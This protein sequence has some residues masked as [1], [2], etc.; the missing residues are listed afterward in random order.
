M[1]L[2]ETLKRM[3]EAAASA[4]KVHW[5]DLRSFAEEE[6]RKLGAAAAQLEAD[7][8]ADRAEALLEPDASTR[9]DLERK[10]KLRAELG[11]ENL[12]L[13]AEGVV[14]MA[15]ADAKIAAQNAI[16]AALGVVRAAINESVGLALL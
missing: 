12:R 9:A 16:N 3:I 8:L 5:A 15:K 11:F 10:A 14:T 4:A 6:M 13:A 2:E 7:Y 1:N